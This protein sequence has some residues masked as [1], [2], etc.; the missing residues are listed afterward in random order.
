MKNL[1]RKILALALVFVLLLPGNVITFAT[2][3]DMNVNLSDQSEISE[4]EEQNSEQM[5]NKEETES[6][7]ES[8]DQ[9]KDVSVDTEDS[10]NDQHNNL[11]VDIGYIFEVSTESGRD[12]YLQLGNDADDFRELKLTVEKDCERREYITTEMIQNVAVFS[13]D[14]QEK[15][16]AVS[17]VVNEIPFTSDL[18]K[19]DATQGIEVPMAE[20]NVEIDSYVADDILENEDAISEAANNACASIPA[21]MSEE[22]SRAAEKIVVIDPGHSKESVGTRRTYN[23]ITYKEEELV[24]KIAKYAEKELKQYTGVTVYLTRTEDSHLS[25]EDRVKFAKSKNADILVSIHINATNEETTLASGV[26]SMVAKIG[27][28]NASNAQKGQNL[29]KIILEQLVALG[30]KDRGLVLQTSQSTYPDGSK[31]DYYGI[32]RYGQIYSVPSIIVEH[33]FINNASDWQ[34]LNNEAG[35]KE[36]GIADAKGIAKYLGLSKYNGPTGW[37]TIN[38]KK[39]Y[40]DSNG[41]PVTGTPV[42]DGKKYWF[43]S[44]GVLKTGW[45]NLLNWKMYFDP[46]TGEAKTGMVDIDGKKYLFNN[47]GVMQNY[48]GTP[49]INGKKYWFSTDGASL[50]TGWLNLGL[51]KLYFDSVTYEAKTGMADIGGKRYLFNN[52]GVMQNYAGTTVVDGKKYWFSTDDASLKTGWLTLGKWTMYFDPQTYQAAVGWKTIDGKKYHFDDN[53][54]LNEGFVKIGNYQYYLR[55]NGTYATGTPVIDGKKYGFD[56]SGRQIFGWYSFL[57]WKF[58]FDPEDNGAAV[59]TTKK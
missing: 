54:V 15:I 33:G 26:E 52:D 2:E 53:G 50:K 44:N 24:Y 41:V 39:Y 23:G 49:V 34:H 36:L 37:Q 1:K 56:S 5:E 9:M 35:L 55:Q 12:V 6:E 57:N 45:L 8:A 31:A 58:Y 40:Y 11:Q 3:I 32:P 18:T 47:D 30:F 22:K 28:Y 51:W 14:E 29:A 10:E 27:N 43:D 17:G 19:I 4:N 46:K 25:I 21:T 16:L 20:D 7:L 38:G 48:A 42:I 13:L 59:T